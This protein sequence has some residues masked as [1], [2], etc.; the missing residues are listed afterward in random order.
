MLN[1]QGYGLYVSSF[2][3]EEFL[4][5]SAHF[6]NGFPDG[7]YTI[8][9][10]KGTNI[11]NTFNTRIEEVSEGWAT[12]TGANGKIGLI[13]KPSNFI[14]AQY[15]KVLEPFSNGRA[16]VQ[17]GEEEFYINTSGTRLENT[18]RYQKIL[19]EREA[20]RKQREIEEQKEAARREAIEKKE[21]A[22]R[23]AENRKAA[24][25]RR[26]YESINGQWVTTSGRITYYRMTY[27]AYSNKLKVEIYDNSGSRT[28]WWSFAEGY[29]SSGGV[30]SVTDNGF[31]G[32]GRVS[33]YY[34]GGNIL[35]FGAQKLRRR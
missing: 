34:S 17:N 3:N 19:D 24:S 8:E 21:A 31:W 15:D 13:G 1:G 11:I 33:I 10:C 18:E 6:I 30:F 4:I 29:M 20:A 12:Y 28:G 23:E 14:L 35:T 26:T 16:C 32:L 25:Q 27:N 9:L 5:I 2:T 22:R 7:N